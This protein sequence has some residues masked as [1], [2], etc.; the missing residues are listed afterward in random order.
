MK[1]G[2]D[3]IVTDLDGT[4]VTS[5]L[6]VKAETVEIIKKIEKKN[7]PFVFAT[8]RVF[9]SVFD[10]HKQYE[11]GNYAIACNGAYI[12]DFKNNKA[13]YERA[14]DREM[15]CSFFHSFASSFKT[16]KLCTR[17]AWYVSPVTN[18]K[19]GSKWT[20][21]VDDI[22]K[23]V[24]NMTESVYKIE[25]FFENIVEKENVIKRIHENFPD[26]EIATMFGN[27]DKN[28]YIEVFN[29][30]INKGTGLLKLCNYL[31]VDPKEVI[32]FGDQGNDLSMFQVVGRGIAVA[33]AIAELKEL[34]TDMTL[35]NDEQGVAKWLE[36]YFSQF[37]KEEKQC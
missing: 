1:T 13:I 29:K 20:V 28:P 16:I 12:Y 34:A 18:V 9:A 24:E 25:C 26:I 35:S 31:H 10:L 30:D 32:A 17:Q 27:H 15:I 5:T 2:D 4:L 3:M 33:N 14:L 36:T 37:D 11:I 8:G 6:E 21:G 23:T 7:I 22:L 19:K